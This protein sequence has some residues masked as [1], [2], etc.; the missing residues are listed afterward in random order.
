M[1][2]FPNAM[3]RRDV[4]KTAVKVA[5]AG[6]TFAALRYEQA[7]AQRKMAKNEAR[8]QDQPNGQQSCAMCASFL[9]PA[10]CKIVQG[11]ISP[12]G[13]CNQFQPRTG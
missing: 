10:A 2:S 12:N 1:P 8:Y 7:F 11:D 6:C 13:W 4:L 9:P 5:G 3:P